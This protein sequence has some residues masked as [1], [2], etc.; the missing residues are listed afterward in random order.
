V[1]AAPLRGLGAQVGFMLEL[2][3]GQEFALRRFADAQG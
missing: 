2:F 3:S 1:L